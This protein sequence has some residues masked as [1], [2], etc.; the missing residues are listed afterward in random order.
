MTAVAFFVFNRADTTARVFDRIRSARPS[1]LFVVA[2]GP[3]AGV[4]DDAHRTD[5][6]RRVVAQVDWP[7]D[8]RREYA[9]RNLGL[10][11]RVATGLSWVFA[12]TEA[13]IVLEDDCLPDPS[14]FPFCGELLDRYATDD[15][16]MSISG[17]QFV[18]AAG[19]RTHSYRFSRQP[20]IWGWATWRRAWQRCDVAMSAWPALRDDRWLETVLSERHEREYWTY[21]FDRNYR[22]AGAGSWDYAWQLACWRAGGLAIHPAVNLVTNVGFRPDGTH[23]KDPR[24]VGAN[25][26]SAAMAFPLRHPADLA[27][28]V[29]ADAALETAM[30]SGHLARLMRHLGNRAR[31]T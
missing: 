13:A 27:R 19:A 15:R 16:V 10:R 1:Q 18:P 25:A 23:G 12:Q 26:A 3:R 7:C 8:V 2:D 14:F 24:Q 5:A 31:A 20:L 28:D 30:F 29:E 4:P 11:E 9:P 21:L 6:V 17:N 22:L